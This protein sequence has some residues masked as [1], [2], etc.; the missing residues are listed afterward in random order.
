MKLARTRRSLTARTLATALLLSTLAVPTTSPMAAAAGNRIAAAPVTPPAGSSKYVPLTPQRIVKSFGTDKFGFTV[1]APKTLRVSVRDRAG[2][3]ATAVAAV[4][5]ITAVAVPAPGYVSVYPT[6]TARPTSSNVNADTTGRTIANLAHVA[7]SANGQFNVFLSADQPV[8]IDLVGVYV[9][10]AD[11]QSDGRFVSR[12]GGSARA[13]DTRNADFG[14]PRLAP[15]TTVTVDLA[16]FGLPAGAGAA[17]VNVTAVKGAKGFWTAFPSGITRPDTSTLNLDTAGQ[18]RGAQAIVQL[19]S[20]ATTINVFSL[21]GGDLVIDFVGWYTGASSPRGVD[22]LFVPSSPSRKLDTRNLRTLAPWAGSTY[23]IAVGS[24]VSCTGCVAAVVANVTGTQPWINGY[25][26]A[27]AAGQ[28]RPSTSTLNLT[29]WPQTIANH[30]IV[31]AST[32]GI[33]LYT[34]SGAHMIVDVAGYFLGTPLAAPN[35]RPTNPSYTSNRA[36]FVSAT[37]APVSV[38]IRTGSNL[39]TIA[40]QGYAAGWTGLTNVAAVGNVML[41]AHRTNSGGPFRYLDQFVVGEKFVL[42][43]S[44]GHRYTYLV[45]D[46]RVTRP[47]YTTVLALAKPWGLATAQLV[48]CSRADG[49]PTSLSYRIVITGRLISVV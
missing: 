20:D 13:L 3:P 22:G 21:S 19:N 28:P 7:L 25:L 9:P 4:I 43:G 23:E 30:A 2:V 32:R 8:V 45:V 24:P 42:T 46:R 5:N 41:F 11:T 10:A 18:T 1:V 26:T 16:P 33:A 39:D 44:D 37:D 14:V 29:A 38:G 27:Y 17:V 12:S 34:L 40:D 15:G 36:T 48:A 6:G 47:E 49:S 31:P 35:P